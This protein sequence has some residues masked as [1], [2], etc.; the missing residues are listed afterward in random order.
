M[1]AYEEIW[2]GDELM[3]DKEA[4]E[5]RMLQKGTK[6]ISLISALTM[7]SAHDE[8]LRWLEYIPKDRLKLL[9]EF[10]FLRN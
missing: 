6:S 10:P 2:N 9:Q 7:G 4:M 1:I 5:H 8:W 3:G